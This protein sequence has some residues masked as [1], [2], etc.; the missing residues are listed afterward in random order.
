M[1]MKLT[2]LQVRVNL[3][4]INFIDTF[5]L[6]SKV[7]QIRVVQFNQQIVWHWESY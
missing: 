7:D 4:L 1:N 6:N 2:G 5:L 3:K